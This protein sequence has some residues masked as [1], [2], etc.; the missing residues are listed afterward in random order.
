MHYNDTGSVGEKILHEMESSSVA[1]GGGEV[2]EDNR[3]ECVSVGTDQG[4]GQ[5][6]EQGPDTSHQRA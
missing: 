4:L 2:V 6:Q 5:G 1:G 3:V